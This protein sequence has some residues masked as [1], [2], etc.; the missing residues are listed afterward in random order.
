M[1]ERLGLASDLHGLNEGPLSFWLVL[2]L[3]LLLGLLGGALRPRRVGSVA[4]A[5]LL[6]LLA[7]SWL[8]Q[9]TDGGALGWTQQ[10]GSLALYW[11]VNGLSM[12]LL[13]L[14]QLLALASALYAARYLYDVVETSERRLACFWPLLGLLVTSLSLL[15]LAADLLLLYIGLEVMGLTAVALM[16]LPG[17]AETR[18]AGLRY[19]LLSLLGSLAFL[20][21]VALLL[22]FWGRLDLAGLAQSVEAGLPL[23]AAVALLSAGLLLK[24]AAFPLHAWL[25]PVHAAAWVPVSALHAGLVIKA[26][27]FIALQLWLVLLPDAAVGARLIG[28]MAGAAVVWG[29]LMAWR[30]VQLKEIVAWSTVSQLGYLLLAF[31]LLIGTGSAVQA[32]AWEGAWLQLAGHSLAKAAMFLATGNLLLATSES[33]LPGLIGASRR[34][35]LA[36]LSFG[37]A[38]IGLIGMP[39]SLGFIAKWQ[40]LH[41]AISGEQWAWVAV[42]GI[43]TLLSAAYVFRVFRYSFVEE[44]PTRD[45]H[46]VPWS[47]DAIALLLALASLL[48]GLVAEWPLA[49][50]RGGGE[51]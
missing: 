51:A 49:L 33:G 19:L 35:P 48:L 50:L 34:F 14:T 15:W 22:G 38:A 47:M 44:G 17:K 40:L 18:R 25:T 29:G 5:G 36:L 31:P 1:I 27:F 13:L 21:G 23:W 6:P 7:L 46:P 3:P 24:A 45:Y 28:V 4:L 43:G 41:A 12:A 16:L 2:G 9:A 37:L 11:R 20:L 32:L 30:A 39:P 26:S 10:V 8:Y 42:L